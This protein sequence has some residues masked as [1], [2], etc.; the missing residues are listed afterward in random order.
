MQQ[1][2]SDAESD[3][4]FDPRE[5]NIVFLGCFKVRWVVVGGENVVGEGVGGN[6]RQLAQ[7]LHLTIAPARKSG[8]IGICVW[9]LV[10]EFIAFSPSERC[11][12]T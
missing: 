11:G 4:S 6:S 10:G 12:C 1:E 7:S 3:S 2:E 8:V 9:I 5:R